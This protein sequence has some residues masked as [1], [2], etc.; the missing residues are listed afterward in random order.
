MQRGS[1]SGS[2]QYDLLIQTT[3]NLYSGGETVT[4]QV[5]LHNSIPLS[6]IDIVV[7][8]NRCEVFQYEDFVASEPSEAVFKMQSCTSPVCFSTVARLAHLQSGSS[9]YDFSL[10]LPLDTPGSVVVGHPE[11][12][13]MHQ[14][15]GKQDFR[16]VASVQRWHM[17]K[18][19][20]IAHSEVPQIIFLRA[21]SE[22]PSFAP[23]SVSSTASWRQKITRCV[24]S[25]LQIT[26]TLEKQCFR[27]GEMASVILD[28]NNASGLRVSTFTIKLNQVVRFG[29]ISQERGWRWRGIKPLWLQK[30]VQDMRYMGIESFSEH[31]NFVYHVTLSGP[32]ATAQ[33]CKAS[34]FEVS[35]HVLVQAWE[36]EAEI[37]RV[38]VPID[39]YL[40]AAHVSSECETHPL[41]REVHD[42][43]LEDLYQMF[44]PLLHHELVD[45]PNCGAKVVNPQ[46]EIMSI[47]DHCSCIMNTPL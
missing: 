18:L 38:K 47:C 46:A 22:S 4:G 30:T 23:L 27:Y 12:P 37:A 19:V 13:N 40:P 15:F 24:R 28:V 41:Q 17:N 21:C 16:I 33:S 45:C 44:P 39:I 1:S 36:R 43:A 34:I 14:N 10:E 2:A 42:P 7:E 5:V 20:S 35:Y 9:I 31:E 29:K 3:K 11:R 26:V 6:D 25:V 32:L 8:C